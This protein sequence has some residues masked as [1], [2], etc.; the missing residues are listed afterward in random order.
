M[1]R[2]I[3]IVPFSSP[4]C[5]GCGGGGQNELSPPTRGAAE[6]SRREVSVTVSVTDPALARGVVQAAGGLASAWPRWS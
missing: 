1:G 6:R 5:A 4:V 2:G 3:E